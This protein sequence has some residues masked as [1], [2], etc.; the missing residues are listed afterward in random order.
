MCLVRT[1]LLLE[2]LLNHKK[3]RSGI[4]PAPQ[5]PEEFAGS[6]IDADRNQ[7]YRGMLGTKAGKQEQ[8]KPKNANNKPNVLATVNENS[9]MKSIDKVRNYMKYNE[10]FKKQKELIEQSEK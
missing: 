2:N 6:Q 5:I 9:S 7:A 3:Q 8:L 10:I 4:S 1:L